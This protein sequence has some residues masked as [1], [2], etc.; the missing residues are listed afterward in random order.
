MVCYDWCH[1]HDCSN[2]TKFLLRYAYLGRFQEEML[3]F[4]RVAVVITPE[5]LKVW[6]LNFLVWNHMALTA[7]HNACNRPSCDSFFP[8]VN[9]NSGPAVDWPSIKY[10]SISV[11]GQ[12][13]KP[14]EPKMRVVP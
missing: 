11:T 14:V 9:R 12:S 4:Q 2:V 13:G 6:P 1:C 7:W 8:F 3:P 10:A 5:I